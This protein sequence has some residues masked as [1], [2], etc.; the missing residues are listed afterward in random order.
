M[1]EMVS[2]DR[3]ARYEPLQRSELP[4]ETVAESDRMKWNETAGDLPIRLGELKLQEK[5]TNRPV[6]S[7]HHPDILNVTGQ[8]GTVAKY[9]PVL[10]FG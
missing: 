7:T 2:Y 8:E 3:V 5:S 4:E 6:T 9:A 10:D 1:L